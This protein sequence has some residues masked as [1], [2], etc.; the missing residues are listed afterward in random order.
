M[1]PPVVSSTA[2]DF[3]TK[4][5]LEQARSQQTLSVKVATSQ[6]VYNFLQDMRHL[7]ILDFRSEELFKKCRIRKS[8]KVDLE[9]YAPILLSVIQDR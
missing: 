4:L 7:V 9:N 5:R 6:Q 3:H 8:L 1:Q 2:I